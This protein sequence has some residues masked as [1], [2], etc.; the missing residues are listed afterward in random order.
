MSDLQKKFL[1][2][3]NIDEAKYNELKEKLLRATYPIQLINDSINTI[4]F[5][6][7]LLIVIS[8]LFQYLRTGKFE[9]TY[10]TMKFSEIYNFF[11]PTQPI[12]LE[13]LKKF[14]L[15][16]RTNKQKFINDIL[17]DK[18]ILN[19]TLVN[20][21]D[22]TKKE[23][24]FSQIIKTVMETH[25][26]FKEFNLINH[27]NH[28]KRYNNVFVI[29]DLH[30]DFRK[31]L[32]ILIK[33]NIVLLPDK[34]SIDNLYEPPEKI[35][36]IKWVTD[37]EWNPIYKKCLLVIVGDLVD[38]KRGKNKVNDP[39]GSFELLIHLLIYNLRISSFFYDS[40][41][42]FTIGNHDYH[43]VIADDGQLNHYI[44]PESLNFFPKENQKNN[45]SRSNILN[46]FYNLSPYFFI[47]L[48]DKDLTELIFVHAGLHYKNVPPPYSNR[49]NQILLEQMQNDINKEGIVD[50]KGN[51]NPKI[52]I[53]LI[54]S[55][56]SSKDTDGAL[57]SRL[58]AEQEAGAC[59]ILKPEKFKTLVVGHCPT[60]VGFHR[61]D[62]IKRESGKLYDSCE[63]ET[64]GCVV[65][66]CLS[67]DG[68]K[69]IF[70]DTGLSQAFYEITSLNSERN[71]DILK[72]S[73]DET[74]ST[75]K[76]WLN[77]IV[78]LKVGGKSHN[79]ETDIWKETIP[80][81]EP[82]PAPAPA[83]APAPEPEPE[84]E[85]EPAPVPP[86][87]TGS[88]KGLQP[89]GP[90]KP[91]LGTGSNTG[92]QPPGPAKPPS[93]NGSSSLITNISAPVNQQKTY[94]LPKTQIEIVKK[95]IPG[96]KE[97]G[98]KF[99]KIKTALNFLLTRKNIPPNKNK[100]R[101]RYTLKRGFK[102]Y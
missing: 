58:Y 101:Q 40:N 28:V 45:L 29:S 81:P 27:N 32:Q 80:A 44:T 73:H 79:I 78:R 85:S 53:S 61:I 87:G 34:L 92:L 11:N 70:S 20:L 67:E 75:N 17:A 68:P 13:S 50:I 41:I 19:R 66:D 91:P 39:R 59:D 63:N 100:K 24:T 8:E 49:I 15:G 42:L 26:L 74:L 38:G 60:S 62:K 3:I 93:G 33:A 82:E 22:K 76:R 97:E 72:F 1:S 95:Y 64:Y 43:T 54:I 16:I 57:W 31:F 25:K 96:E 65:A 30:S 84:P 52:K 37:L 56:P 102:N 46:Q 10:E 88:N 18:K 12:N 48:S 6:N 36:D 77:K 51:P 94:I 55:N 98:E 99:E 90:A 4:N 89:P 86:S 2:I 7:Y 83:P 47:K 14:L 35:Y 71:I 21:Y 23:E 5:Y 69:L 9:E